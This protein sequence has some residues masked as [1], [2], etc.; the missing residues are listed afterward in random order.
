MMPIFLWRSAKVVLSTAMIA[1]LGFA[2]GVKE[3]AAATHKCA[4]KFKGPPRDIDFL[5]NQK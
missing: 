1:V 3:E 2:Q 4:T 5:S